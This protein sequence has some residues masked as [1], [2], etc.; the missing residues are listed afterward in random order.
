METDP[1]RLAQR[2]RQID[3]GKNTDEYEAYVACEDPD[4]PYI[5][6]PNK[7]QIRSKRSW[8]GIVSEWRRRLHAWYDEHYLFIP[9]QNIYCVVCNE[10]AQFREA[11]VNGKYFCGKECQQT[12]RKGHIYY[13]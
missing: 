3:I 9:D 5:P 2:Q 10:R 8:D 13:T 4:K 6:I 11:G 7:F 1:H 12:L